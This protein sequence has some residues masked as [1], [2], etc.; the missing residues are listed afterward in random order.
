MGLDFFSSFFFSSSFTEDTETARFGHRQVS[1]RGSRLF[2]FL[3]RGINI[4]GV[5]RVLASFC[6][7]IL[8]RG[9]LF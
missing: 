2:F 5:S 4:K 8:V 1:G 3:D 7:L 6:F 9:C